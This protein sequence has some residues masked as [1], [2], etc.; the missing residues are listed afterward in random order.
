MTLT[1]GSIRAAF[2]SART[3]AAVFGTNRKRAVWSGPIFFTTANVIETDTVPRTIMRTRRD[4]KLGT[5]PF[6][7][8][9]GVR[10]KDYCH[11][12]GFAQQPR[13]LSPSTEAAEQQR[14]VRRVAVVDEHVVVGALRVHLS[15]C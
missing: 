15:K 2:A 14:I 1:T 9:V 13:G 3:V 10:K 11:G 5:E 6:E 7:D 12:A 4:R 8:V